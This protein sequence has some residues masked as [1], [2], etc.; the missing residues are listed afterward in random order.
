MK[1][2][3][4]CHTHHS[5]GTKI[6]W[7]GLN[8]P[9]DVIKS[10]K[11][12][13]IGGVAITDHNS[14]KAW[15]EAAETAKKEGI[16]FIPAIEISSGKGHILGLGLNDY[17]RS[18]LSVEETVDRIHQQGGVAIAAHP[19]DIKGEGIQ[20]EFV[21]ADAAEA[22][23]AL[24]VDLFANRFTERKIRKT[25]MPMTVGS[26]AHSVE[27]LGHA[28]NIV[29][30]DNVDDF[31][32][33][34]RKGEIRHQKRY[35]PVSMIAMWAKHRMEKSYGYTMDYIHENYWG[36]KKWLAGYMLNKYVHSNRTRIWNVVGLVSVNVSRMYGGVKVL[37]YY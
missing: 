7:E 15:K 17:I 13:G 32:R 37:S 33:K 20:D 4:H 36:P 25:G 16:V 3:I 27:M 35:I 19:Y 10:A 6:I 29:D 8:S 2:E 30:A 12:K 26:D 1:Y 9:A 22:F 14:N 11:K 24:N 31:L 21:K 5:V 23:N 34:I 18:G 28:L